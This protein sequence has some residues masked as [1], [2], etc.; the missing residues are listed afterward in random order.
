MTKKKNLKFILAF[1][2]IA[3][4]SALTMS[5]TGAWFTSNKYVGGTVTMGVVDI[6]IYNGTTSVGNN[7]TFMSK[8][9][10]PGDKILSNALTIKSTKINTSAFIRLTVFV[11]NASVGYVGTSATS[12]GVD[13]LLPGSP[14][15]WYK[16]SND[17]VTINSV[18]YARITYVL[19]TSASAATAKSAADIKAGTGLAI[20]SNGIYILN[21]S[22]STAGFSFYIRVD[23]IQTSGV[24]A[25]PTG[26][27]NALGAVA[28]WDA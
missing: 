1:C 25:T 3:V 13:H 21:S 12:G 15:E 11:T 6:D 22:T 17:T 14:N 28:K 8:T 4:V 16:L 23:A 10:L 18:V 27:N 2:L 20:Y 19:A 5:L 9:A 26:V 24:T 7:A